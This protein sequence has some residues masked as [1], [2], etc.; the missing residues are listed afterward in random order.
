MTANFAV[1]MKQCLTPWDSLYYKQMRWGGRVHV[2]TMH[3]YYIAGVGQ[4]VIFS[5]ISITAHPSFNQGSYG[6]QRRNSAIERGERDMA[7][8]AREQG[9]GGGEGGGGGITR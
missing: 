9:I 2:H 6:Q 8:R 3:V 5:A 1:T 4:G 7:A